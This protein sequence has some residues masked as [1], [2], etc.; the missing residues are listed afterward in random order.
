MQNTHR[1]EI[2]SLSDKDIQLLRKT[3][4]RLTELF[5]ENGKNDS[6][7][8]DLMHLS[9]LITQVIATSKEA[10]VLALLPIIEPLKIKAKSRP[11]LLSHIDSVIK[12]LKLPSY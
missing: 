12:H 11:E 7:V 4:C 6:V 1:Q 8:R 10:N 3:Y 9:D 5:Y 2:H